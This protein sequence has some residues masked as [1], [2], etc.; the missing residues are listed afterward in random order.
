MSLST[1]EAEYIALTEGVK[2]GSWLR[3]LISDLGV[4]QSRVTIHCDSQSAI[5]LANH[6]SYHERTKHIDIRFH[7]IRDV[8]EAKKVQVVNIASEENPADMLTKSLPRTKF[9]QCLDL[10]NFTC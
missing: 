9:K 8:I 10:V 7:F 4:H 6:H 3:G 2:E 5:H 1:T